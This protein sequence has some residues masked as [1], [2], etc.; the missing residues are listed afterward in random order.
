MQKLKYW[1]AAARLRT[2]P[3]SVSGIIAGSSL[4]GFINQQ[5]NQV[6]AIQTNDYYI[7]LVLY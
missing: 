6:L 3:L 5:F 1:L 2:L 4:S 7:F